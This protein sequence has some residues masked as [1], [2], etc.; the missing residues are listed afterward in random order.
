MFLCSPDANYVTGVVLLVDGG[1]GTGWTHMP[2]RSLN[3]RGCPV[4]ASASMRNRRRRK[5]GCPFGGQAKTPP[6]RGLLWVSREGFEP[7]TS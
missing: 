2:Y 7:S 3:P 1:M 6:K 4:L 5:G